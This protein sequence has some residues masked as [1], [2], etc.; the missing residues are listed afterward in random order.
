MWPIMNDE[1]SVLL[2]YAA[3]FK[4]FENRPL[5][6]KNFIDNGLEVPEVFK[7]LDKKYRAKHQS[8]MD[9]VPTLFEACREVVRD[10]LIKHN[11]MNLFQVVNMLPLPK[12]V[13]KYLLYNASLD[14]DT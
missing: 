11:T 10:E 14:I 6:L 7:H 2:L 9:T 12:D 5:N 3:G 8:R 4:D 1:E 13:N